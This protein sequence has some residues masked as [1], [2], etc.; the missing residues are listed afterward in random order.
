MVAWFWEE[1]GGLVYPASFAVFCHRLGCHYVVEPPAHVSIY[2]SSC[3]VVPEGVI[4]AVRAEFSEHVLEAPVFYGIEAVDNFLVVTDVAPVSL[5]LVDV[6]LV[7]CDV[8]IA[9]PDY[10]IFRGEVV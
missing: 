3:A 2:A 8:E 10:F 9:D 4:F 1:A 5:G 6:A 7:H